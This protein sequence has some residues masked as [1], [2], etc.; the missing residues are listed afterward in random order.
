[1]YNH[2]II[3]NLIIKKTWDRRRVIAPLSLRGGVGVGVGGT[4]AFLAVTPMFDVTQLECS[5]HL[6]T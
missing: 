5:V 6:H 3:Y 2:I 4:I 1:M